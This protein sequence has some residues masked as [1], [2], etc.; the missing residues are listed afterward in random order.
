MHSTNYFNTLILPSP[1]CRAD[2]A[3]VPVKPGS[4]G[5]MQYEMLNDNPIELTSDDLIVAVQ[6]RRKD[7]PESEWDDFRAE[8]FSRGQ[9]CLRASPLVKSFGW[10]LYHDAEGRVML[11]DPAS[12][13]FARLESDPEVAKIAG[14]RNKRAT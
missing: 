8:Y 7:I 9:A 1:D 13:E 3:C 4:V 10:A 5:R 2:T 12:A 14:M 11:V 6:C